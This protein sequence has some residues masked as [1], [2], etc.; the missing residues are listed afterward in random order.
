MTKVCNTCG[1]NKPLSEYYKNSWTK[2]GYRGDCKSCN[3]IKVSKWVDS[4]L[5]RK[6]KNNKIWK[7]R[8]PENARDNYLKRTYGITLDQYNELLEK[9]NHSCAVCKR[10]YTEFKV[11]L[12][13]EH[14]HKT[15]EIQGLCCTHCNRN[16]IGKIRNPEL[17]RNAAHYL[18]HSH[19]GWFVP[20]KKKKKRKKK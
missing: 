15:K 6:L 13:V 1:Q 3:K 7:N 9:Q 17:F 5:E 2:S 10:H 14:D 8:N 19:T 12:A 16:L 20:E 11:N 4:N 18:E